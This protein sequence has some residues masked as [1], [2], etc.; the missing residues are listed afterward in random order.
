MANITKRKG[1]YLITVSAGRDV[2]GKQIRK[3]FTWKPDENMTERQIEKELN[4]IA[5]EFETKVTSGNYFDGS[6]RLI[7]YAKKYM[8]INKKHL[9][10][11]TYERYQ[12]LLVRI[13]EAIG[14]I[15]LEKLQPIHLQEFYNN[16]AENGIKQVRITFTANN[17]LEAITKKNISKIKLGKIANVGIATIKKACDGGK[18][19]KE[20]AEAI[21][22]A[23]EIDFKKLFNE[24]TVSNGLSEQTIKH[25]HR[26]I[27]SILSQATREQIIARNIA[28]R[29]YMKAPK[30]T[31]KEPAYLDDIEA[32]NFVNILLNEA[33]IRI[34]TSLLLLVYSGL[35]LG[36]LLGLEWQDIDFQNQII[37]VL[38]ASQ[39]IAGKG[40]ITKGLKNESSKRTIKLPKEIFNI[41][42]EYKN[43][44]NEQRLIN[45]DRWINSNRLFIKENGLPLYPNTVNEWLQAIIQKHKL[46]HFTPHSLRHTNITLQIMAGVPIKQISQRAGHSQTSTTS[47]IYAHS[48]KTADE[49]ASQVLDDILTPKSKKK[50]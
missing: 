1:S 34:K 11:K 28:S 16:L 2:K 8:E 37:Q 44:Y 6:T 10:P 22:N 39:Y 35:R 20:K 43:W 23:L 30:I 19:E 46:K 33:D 12:G 21:A 17:L 15:R 29:D 24:S 45:G 13:Y 4:R 47:N 9:A 49:I 41:L 7:D 32:K 50:A 36:E 42:S 18:I 25:H 14:H 27:A 31:K 48:I 40:I 5:V 3:Y 38:R 26:L